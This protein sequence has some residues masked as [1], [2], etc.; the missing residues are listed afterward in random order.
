MLFHRPDQV[1]H[2]RTPD[3]QI[4]T[5]QAHEAESAFKSG[6][7]PVNEDEFK[8][9][10]DEAR[11]GGLKGAAIAGA[12]G[13]A[14]GAS[15]GISDPLATGVARVLG[16]KKYADAVRRH[17]AGE[18]STNP[19]SAGVGEGVGFVASAI[20]APE[21]KL[22]EVG[23]LGKAADV[24]KSAEALSPAAR[25]VTEG[26]SPGID[27]AIATVTHGDPVAPFTPPLSAERVNALDRLD[28]AAQARPS[29]PIP[30]ED[31]V[32]RALALEK[33][34]QRQAQLAANGIEN[35]ESPLESLQHL[36]QP[37]PPVIG[38]NGP[39]D[40]ALL[41]SA[42]T[43]P[44]G[45]A[46]PPSMAALG[47]EAPAN[48]A[49]AAEH[50][51][52]RIQEGPSLTTKVLGQS[53]AAYIS[54]AG[55]AVEGMAQGAVSEIFGEGVAK[56]AAGRV[57]TG[58]LK[59][60]ASGALEQGLMTV[61]SEISEDT[62]G[63]HEINAQK[64]LYAFEHGSL[65]GA[66]FGGAL[67]GG[68]SLAK[69]ASTAFLRKFAPSIAKMR[70]LATLKAF[71]QGGGRGSVERDLLREFGPTFPEKVADVAHKYDIL[72][73]APDIEG[74]Y[75]KTQ[76]VRSEVVGKELGDMI[77]AS[78]TVSKDE[79]YSRAFAKGGPDSFGHDLISDMQ[80]NRIAHGNM[81]GITAEEEASMPALKD[82]IDGPLSERW[83]AARR[84]KR[85]LDEIAKYTKGDAERA[86]AFQ[87][88]DKATLAMDN[89]M[90]DLRAART[91]FS[92][93]VKANEGSALNKELAGISHIFGPDGK[94][95][96]GDLRAERM[97]IDGLIKSWAGRGPSG[98]ELP[99]KQ[100]LLKHLR[101]VMED[102][103]V[104]SGER[105]MGVMGKQWAAGYK[106]LKQDY[107]VLSLLQKK[108]EGSLA[109]RYRN[110]GFSLTSKMLGAAEFM[111]AGAMALPKAALAMAAHKAWR[112][113]GMSASSLVLDK[114]SQMALIQRTTAQVDRQI[115]AGSEGLL[116]RITKGKARVRVRTLGKTPEAT[117]DHLEARDNTHERIAY[118]ASLANA[119]K[120]AVEHAAPALGGNTTNAP[121]T[122]AALASRANVV[123]QYLLS[124]LPKGHDAVGDITG[125]E[126]SK[127]S[128]A[129]LRDFHSRY[130]GAVDL[131]ATMRKVASGHV[132]AGH[133]DGLK[134]AASDIHAQ[135]VANIMQGIADMSP[136]E[137]RRIPMQ[138]QMEIS[139]ITGQPV[140]WATQPS[141]ISLF[142]SQDVQISQSDGRPAQ[143]KQ[144][145]GR[146]G[147]LKGSLAKQSDPE[148]SKLIGPRTGD[149]S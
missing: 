27:D 119:P 38:P 133:I 120:V 99:A 20:A 18:K 21:S 100:L 5:I 107:H 110:Q 6:Y 56:S 148:S 146:P 140:S 39:I 143:G 77:P 45:I 76:E 137:R 94:A 52:S 136:E 96:V 121:K 144:A 61:G 72:E 101:G 128:D 14:R 123:T 15:G 90:E 149:N 70:G 32:Q 69:E 64:L 92:E 98:P 53:P 113:R 131:K 33:L 147:K 22:A 73:G 95:A 31:A 122:A 57:L 24:A 42:P 93:L 36:T 83:I 112:D 19:I 34:E 84:T 46:P 81:A 54:R 26:A 111:H 86:V 68:G 117:E 4:G 114:L 127:L 66:A 102:M 37:K 9:A 138:A 3:G 2:I 80:Q 7:E 88:A 97:R 10:A 43:P 89:A 58:A 135:L 134:S 129:E 50:I 51:V 124:I 85:D 145:P 13:I 59:Y 106:T 78:A 104:E 47:V 12:E 28:A 35:P 48:V 87:Q 74:I 116:S 17:L 55:R 67:G 41:Y 62:L 139:I 8:K 1:V 65:V 40:P 142:Q 103:I 141:S 29:A 49:D 23:E 44:P 30:G 79:L 115:E 16:G 25:A 126:Q 91:Q 63:D 105:E 118:V 75:N 109:A 125:P 11:Y 132:T 82:Q 130:E 60:G 71:G 108:A